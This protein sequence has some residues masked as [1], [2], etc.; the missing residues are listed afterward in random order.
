MFIIIGYTNT[1]TLN[2]SDNNKNNHNKSLNSAVTQIMDKI[3]QADFNIKG[4]NALK[5]DECQ[6]QLDRFTCSASTP[7]ATIIMATENGNTTENN[8]K[9]PI[10]LKIFIKGRIR[11]G[12]IVKIRLQD[13]Y[14]NMKN[15]NLKTN[16]NTNRRELRRIDKELERTYSRLASATK[17]ISRMMLPMSVDV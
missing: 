10:D 13:A 9:I 3:A 15:L 11:H 7:N 17:R 8:G 16:M 14:V 6:S 4:L 1:E 2:P 12:K 5:L